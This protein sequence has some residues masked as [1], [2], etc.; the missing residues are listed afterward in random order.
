MESDNRL[1]EI[2]KGSIL[3]VFGKYKRYKMV[4]DFPKDMIGIFVNCTCNCNWTSY[5]L[6]FYT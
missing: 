2:K 3:K 4:Q 5:S 1:E 6:T